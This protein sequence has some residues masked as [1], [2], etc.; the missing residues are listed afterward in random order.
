MMIIGVSRWSFICI[1]GC[2]ERPQEAFYTIV[3]IE[4]SKSY[5]LR[6]LINLW[7]LYKPHEERL[8]RKKNKK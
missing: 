8:K 6:P 3:S 4:E 1:E 7:D 5:L 2:K